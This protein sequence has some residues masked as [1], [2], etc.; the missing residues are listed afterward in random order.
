MVTGCKFLGTVEGSS[1]W[2]WFVQEAA[3]ESAEAEALNKAAAMGA[4]HFIWTQTDSARWS[5]RV[6]GR[7]YACK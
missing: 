3:I 4:T 2:G 6:W 5:H 1:L 7:A